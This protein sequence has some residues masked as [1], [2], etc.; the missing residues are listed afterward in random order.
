MPLL[1]QKFGGTSVANTEVIQTTA[2]HVAN[3][4]QNGQKV[5]VVVSAMAGVTDQLIGY[6]RQV[7]VA[8]DAREYDMVVSAG[9]QVTCGLMALV[10]KNMGI[11]AQSWLGW[12]IPIITTDTHTQGRICEVDKNRL[13]ECL[14][15]GIVPVVAGFQGMTSNQAITTLGRGGSDLTAV[16]LAATLK[17]DRCD[18]YKDVD[19]IFTADPKIVSRAR[20]LEY[21][22]CEEMLELSS[23]GSKVLQTRAVEMAIAH[24]VRLRVVPTFGKFKGTLIV[25][26]EEMM[27]KGLIRGVVCN[28][29]EAKITLQGIQDS[30]KASAELFGCLAAAHIN[31]D[32][33]H[34]HLAENSQQAHSISFTVP[35]TELQQAMALTQNHASIIGF[36][37]LVQN[38][39]I[40]KISIVGIGLR[41]HA[42][43]AHT[44]FKT[45][46][47]RN[48]PVHGISTSEIKI[49]VLIDEE[50]A[51]LA[52]RTLHTAYG[53]DKEEFYDRCA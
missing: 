53:L 16:A 42:H 33:V 34:H 6:V 27:E 20:Q 11:P 48:I 31:I 23:L 17:A 2:Q 5:I 39:Q 30:S 13:A 9:E 47:E 50:Y 52:T 29:G 12:Q 44:L 26:E 10:L 21:V 19:G 15:K 24:N 37:N 40:A 41:S 14:D 18:L 45:L 7:A 49:S 38:D 43:F 1:I 25:D 46:A 28:Q 3:A 36:N 4:Y 32:M 35:R 22:S 8:P 51:E